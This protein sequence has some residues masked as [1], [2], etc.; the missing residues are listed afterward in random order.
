MSETSNI[1][2]IARKVAKDIFGVFGW[3]TIGPKDHDFTCVQPDKHEKRTHPSDVVFWY[4][5]P[6]AN[7]KVFLN[8]D[9]KSWKKDT[10]SKPKIR[11]EIASLCQA[12]ECANIS[13]QWTELFGDSTTAFQ[14]HGLLFLFNRDSALESNVSRI[15]GD[16]RADDFSLPKNYRVFV[17][18]P[19]TIV[20][21]AAVANDIRV[22]CG[23]GSL[24]GL[25]K[26]KFYYPDLVDVRPKSNERTVAKG[27]AISKM[28]WTVRET[29][30]IG[31]V[32][33][34]MAEF[35]GEGSSEF[36]YDVIG[37]YTRQEDGSLNQTRFPMRGAEKQRFLDLLEASAYASLAEIRAAGQST[38]S[39]IGESD[40]Q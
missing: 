9:L 32:V 3:Q 18:T 27:Y 12:T 35:R 5:D 14:V 29:A 31:D 34:L 7:Q 24:P 33:E 26:F 6:Y 13:P 2:E 17:F 11:G 19:E 22:S 37:K 38:S 16:Y 21:L 39:A 15:L 1:A 4:E 36:R 25:E 20:Y 28:V 40:G 8:T 10:F 23:E 30:N